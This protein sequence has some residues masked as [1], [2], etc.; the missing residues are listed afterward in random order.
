[1]KKRVH[2][3]LASIVAPV[4]LPGMICL[5]P[6]KSL[7]AS[8][9]DCDKVMEELNSG[10]KPRQVASDLHISRSSVYRCRKRARKAAKKAGETAPAGAA[11][12]PAASPSP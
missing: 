6:V 4:V 5:T 10:K 1:V 2:S 9:E 12:A 11:A 7:A 8:K 3:I